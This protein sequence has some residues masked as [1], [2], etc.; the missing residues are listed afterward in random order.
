MN[1]IRAI[2]AEKKEKCRKDN[3]VV[4][5][6]VLDTLIENGLISLRMTK[7]DHRYFQGYLQSLEE[8]RDLITK[9]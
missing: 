3:V 2:K 1:K 7:A 9:P 6:E 8:F 4:I 5:R